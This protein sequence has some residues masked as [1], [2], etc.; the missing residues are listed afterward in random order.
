V[1]KKTGQFKVTERLKFT[2]F[3]TETKIFTGL[4]RVITSAKFRNE[5]F[6]GH[7]SRFYR[8]SN[9]RLSYWF[10]HMPTSFNSAACSAN[11]SLHGVIFQYSLTCDVSCCNKHYAHSVLNASLMIMMMM[12]SWTDKP[13]RQP[14][15]QRSD[16]ACTPA[17]NWAR[18]RWGDEAI[19]SNWRHAGAAACSSIAV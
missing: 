4:G 11:A 2:Y 1:V 10:L 14:Y 19:F 8:E 18:V 5:F 7:E 6:M 16:H 13:A 3:E 15:H 9:C 17:D 12:K